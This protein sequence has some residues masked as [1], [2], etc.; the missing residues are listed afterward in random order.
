MIRFD[1]SDGV[2]DYLASFF[3]SVLHQILGG[4]LVLT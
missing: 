4:N 2:F 1:Q 3:F